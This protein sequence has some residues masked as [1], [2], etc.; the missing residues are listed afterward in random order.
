M[1]I[2]VGFDCCLSK[3][4]GLTVILFLQDYRLSMEEGKKICSSRTQTRDVSFQIVYGSAGKFYYEN[5]VRL[6]CSVFCHACPLN[7]LVH[8][9]VTSVQRF[10]SSS[11]GQTKVV[12]SSHWKERRQKD[13]DS[14]AVLSVASGGCNCS[15]LPTAH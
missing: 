14:C 10:N 9:C 15:N 3:S 4:W 1:Y 13:A 12:N 8:L 11:I 2:Y 7:C 5:V 6:K